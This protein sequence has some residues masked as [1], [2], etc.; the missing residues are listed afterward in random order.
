M[1]D[2]CPTGA[3]FNMFSE[4]VHACMEGTGVAKL[5]NMHMKRIECISFN[6]SLRGE[7]WSHITSLSPPFCLCQ[8]KKASS[9]VFVLGKSLVT[10]SMDFL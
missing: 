7:V 1:H 2:R 6:D 5:T 8:S 3:I 4:C 10:L 9:D